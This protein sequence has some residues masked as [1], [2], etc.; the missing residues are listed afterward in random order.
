MKIFCAEGMSQKMVGWGS[1]R[2]KRL[3]EYA[4][5]L[6]LR[7]ASALVR[8]G[9]PPPLQFADRHYGLF[10]EWLGWG[11]DADERRLRRKKNVGAGTFPSQSGELQM[12]L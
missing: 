12:S 10:L 2:P 4:S 7:L 8:A 6:S 11:K 1:A 9:R 3:A 5:Y